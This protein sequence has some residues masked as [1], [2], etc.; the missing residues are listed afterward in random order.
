[1]LKI[2]N[3]NQIYLTR[4]DT[5]DIQVTILDS[6]GE[7]YELQANDVVRFALKNHYCDAEPLMI[8]TLDHESL[9]LRLEA[10]ETKLLS[11]YSSPYYFDFELTS[12]TNVD[13]FLAGELW[14]TEEVV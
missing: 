4:G 12:G 2:E 9:E 1:M 14:I 6:D 5:L 11:V 7:V 10:S 13:T 8:K 3:E